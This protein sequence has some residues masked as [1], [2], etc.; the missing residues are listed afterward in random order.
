MENKEVSKLNDFIL[1]TEA[2]T[3]L[4]TN[5]ETLRNWTRSGKITCYTN[6]INKYRMFKKEDL[7][8]FLNDLNGDSSNK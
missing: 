5:K 2:A 8:K 3:Y 1:V 6:K 7:D 4:G